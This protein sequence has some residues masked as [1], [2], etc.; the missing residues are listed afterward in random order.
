[1]EMTKNNTLAPTMEPAR[2]F[3]F[4]D[5]LRE[6]NEKKSAELGRRLTYH[7]ETFGCPTV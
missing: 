1:M 6:Y 5:L 2:Q 3:Y 4:M 7:I